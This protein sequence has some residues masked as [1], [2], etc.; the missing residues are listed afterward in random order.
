MAQVNEQQKPSFCQNL[1]QQ[2]SSFGKFLYNSETGEVIGRGGQSWGKCIFRTI[3]SNVYTT[4]NQ[5][6]YFEKG[7]GQ[8]FEY[9][10]A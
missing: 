8:Q 7:C 9:Y 1:S 2:C 3:F 6:F 5:L 4:P 10:K